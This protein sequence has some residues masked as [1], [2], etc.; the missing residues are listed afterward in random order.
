M[1]TNDVGVTKNFKEIKD[2]GYQAWA[3]ADNLEGI[4]EQAK[5]MQ[6]ILGGIGGITLLVAALG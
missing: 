2:M 1:R 5:V 3:M 4:E 6:A